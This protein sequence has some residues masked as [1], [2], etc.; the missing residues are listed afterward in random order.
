MLSHAL[1]NGDIQVIGTADFKGYR[2]TFDKDPSLA[3]KFQNLINY[4]LNIFHILTIF[5]ATCLQEH[6]SKTYVSKLSET[7]RTKKYRSKL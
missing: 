4:S 3:R 6:V 5:L 2:N 1:D 7:F